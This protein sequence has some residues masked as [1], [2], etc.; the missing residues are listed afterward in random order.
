MRNINKRTVDLQKA[1]VSKFN[2]S[3]LPHF[4]IMGDVPHGAFI[5]LMWQSQGVQTKTAPGYTIEDQMRETAK[6]L[7]ASLGQY[8]VLLFLDIDCVPVSIDAIDYYIQKAS[9]GILIGNAQRSGHLQ[10]NN[11][12]FA[13]PSAAAISKETFLKIGSPAAGETPRSDVLEEY[14]FEA[15]SAGVKVDFTL[16]VRYDREVY[17]YDWEQDKRPYWTLENGLPN[18]GLGTTYGNEELGDLFWHNFQIRIPGNE[19][20]F[21]EKCEELLK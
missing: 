14:T 17:R 7:G 21:W 19:Q 9:E 5:D 20:K 13:A 1:V 16:P 15:E 8:D 4:S 12:V 11:H 6:R 2:K 18:F 3:K 10:N